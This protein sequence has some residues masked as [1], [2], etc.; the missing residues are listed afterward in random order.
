MPPTPAAVKILLQKQEDEHQ[1][2]EQSE[3]AEGFAEIGQPEVSVSS[4]SSK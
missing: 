1:P 4:S 2:K 3:V